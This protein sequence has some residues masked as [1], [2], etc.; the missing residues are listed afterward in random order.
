MGTRIPL[1]QNLRA[2]PFTTAAGLGSGLNPGRLRGRDLH[3]PYRGVRSAAPVDSLLERCHALQRRMR[4]DAFFC[5]VTAALIMGVP[6]PWRLEASPILH[7]A[8]PSPRRAPSGVG[9]AGHK[10]LA[11]DDQ[12][13]VWRGLRIASPEATWCEL[14]RILSVPD[15]VAA[16]DFLIHH[17]L[18]ITTQGRLAAT[19]AERLGRR[20]MTSLRQALP[21]LNDRAESRKESLVRVLLIQAGISGLVANL[22]I[23]TSGG[24]DYRA[25]L[26]VPSR[27]VIIEYQSDYHAGTE[28]FR[29]DMTRI[30]RLEADG[31]YVIQ[32]NADD[33]RNPAELL[34]R[35]RKV[36][37][38]RPTVA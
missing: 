26:A 12:S 27:K 10:L 24:F 7:V 14:G 9:I 18:P 33:L 3:K 28:Q 8:V 34:Q 15:L 2:E 17:E 35:I 16:G 11:G 5:S 30:S 20:G 19:M 31:W 4:D 22:P 36:L 13:R 21:L 38:S 37:T 1:P 6:L 23:T 25:D 29:A 32:V